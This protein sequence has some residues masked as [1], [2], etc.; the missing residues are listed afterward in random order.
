MSH[1]DPRITPISGDVLRSGTGGRE[2]HVTGFYKDS[3][4]SYRSTGTCGAMD[5][6]PA[7]VGCKNRRDE[8]HPNRRF[9]VP[10]TLQAR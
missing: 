4:V 10:P 2:R 5:C 7:T 3:E 8:R 9:H 6:S 1:R